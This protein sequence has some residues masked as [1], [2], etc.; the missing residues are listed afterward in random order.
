MFEGDKE[1]TYVST[2]PLTVNGT[3]TVSLTASGVT[4][5]DLSLTTINNKTFV[6]T[7]PIEGM[8][9][10]AENGSIVFNITGLRVD[11]T[12]FNYSANQT[13]NKIDSGTDGKDIEYIYTRT[14]SN[15]APPAPSSSVNT[16]E[17]VPVEEG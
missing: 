10:A 13:F 16:D 4:P 12:T 5:G 6:R 11:G 2:P 15:V 1:L 7:T 14:T 3:Y 8:N 17:Y 9:E